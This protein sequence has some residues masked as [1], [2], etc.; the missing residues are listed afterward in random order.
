[1]TTIQPPP[2]SPVSGTVLITITALLLSITPFSL[3]INPCAVALAVLLVAAALILRDIQS[4]HIT[5]FAALLTAIPGL[6]PAL[7]DWPFNL[8]LPL[9]LYG[10]IVPAV[11]RLRRSAL[12]MRAG[13]TGKDVLL[14]VMVVAAVSGTALYAWY[15]LLRP[16]LSPHLGH[17]PSLPARLLPL[18]GI[19]FAAGNAAAEEF[20]FRGIIMQ[21]TDSAFG[22][23]MFSIVVQACPFSAMHFLRGFPNGG[24]GLAMTFV[25]GMML[26]AV[27]RRSQGMLAPWLAHVLADLVIFAI[28]AAVRA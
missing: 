13:R 24:W 27:R 19:C 2:R 26:G 20:V 23:G 5:I 15:A 12:W 4:V 10:T 17:M 16:D 9:V 28:L 25:Y 14:I 18:V 6:N 3:R 21:A 8:L 7:R 22:P 1:M 11:P